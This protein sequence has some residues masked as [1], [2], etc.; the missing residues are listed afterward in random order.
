MRNKEGGHGQGH[1]TK[2]VPEYLAAYALNLAGANIRLMVEAFKVLPTL[3][4]VQQ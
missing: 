2:E 1:M 3:P 4:A